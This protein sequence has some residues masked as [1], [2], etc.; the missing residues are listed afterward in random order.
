MSSSIISAG[1][2]HNKNHSY[3]YLG[4]AAAGDLR[5]SS[6]A[7]KCSE[8]SRLSDSSVFVYWRVHKVHCSLENGT[9]KNLV[10]IITSNR[11]NGIA[12]IHWPRVPGV[13]KYYCTRDV[14]FHVI[15][16]VAAAFRPWQT[17]AENRK[18]THLQFF[19]RGS[20]MMR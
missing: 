1:S 13:I 8:K 20:G 18:P 12:Y 9:A 7:E 10:S 17:S 2:T 19:F 16:S 11:W 3:N 6:A 5:Y 4:C 14:Y 15:S